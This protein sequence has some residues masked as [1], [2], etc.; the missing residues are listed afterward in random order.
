MEPLRVVH[1]S[2]QRM[3]LFDAVGRTR[4]RAEYTAV[5]LDDAFWPF[6]RTPATV[7]VGDLRTPT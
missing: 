4:L 1:D 2:G 7:T 6:G 5:S 3:V